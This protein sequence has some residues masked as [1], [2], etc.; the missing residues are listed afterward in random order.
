MKHERKRAI[1]HQ[2]CPSQG[3]PKGRSG[4]EEISCRSEGTQR[5]PHPKERR[6]TAKFKS[7]GKAARV[8]DR[9]EGQESSEN[10]KESRVR[11]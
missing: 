11:K 4:K 1:R 5:K 3:V 8:H 10:V 7:V 9:E 6:K 2:T